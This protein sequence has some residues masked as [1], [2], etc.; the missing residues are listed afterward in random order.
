MLSF[1]AEYFVFRLLSKNIMIKTYRTII[2][3]FVLYGCE[4][5]LVTMREERR[6]RVFENKLLKR[7]FVPKM[8][9]V[10]AEWRKLCNEE[11]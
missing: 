5:W 1:S 3:P 4:T 10:I 6:L 9:E 2:F 8:D 11:Q 7:I